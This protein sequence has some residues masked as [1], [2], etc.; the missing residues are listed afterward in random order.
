MQKRAPFLL[1]FSIAFGIMVLSTSTG[2]LFGGEVKETFANISEGALLSTIPKW[3][4]ADGGTDNWVLASFGGSDG[5]GFEA[6]ALGSY[7]RGLSDSEALTDSRPY[8]FMA[9]IRFT[10]STAYASIHIDLL[11]S[12]GVNG[13]GIRFDGGEADGA[14]ANVISVSESGASWGDVKC[15]TVDNAH[16]QSNVWYQIEIDNINITASGPVG[17]VTIYDKSNP[18][19]KLVD[20]SP[21][22]AYGSAG[23]ITKVDMISISSVGA[24]RP[25]QMG[26]I[27]LVRSKDKDKDKDKDISK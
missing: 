25:F 9:K 3:N 13:L 7:R 15:H 27:E 21:I 14:S 5:N 10:G 2:T 20:K 4:H 26:D 24:E 1:V 18:S 22:S 12:G 19:N 17:T 6:G 11:E 16:W 23:G 8:T